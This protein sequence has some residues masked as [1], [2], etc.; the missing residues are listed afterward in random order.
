MSFCPGKS[1][2]RKYICKTGKREFQIILKVDNFPYKE[3]LSYNML[4][5]WSYGE[6]VQRC[7][8]RN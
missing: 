7:P 1:G 5:T 6:N 8:K 2:Y 4:F 3:T